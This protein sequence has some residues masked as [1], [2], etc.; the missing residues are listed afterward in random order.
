MFEGKRYMT[1]GV[2]E[3]VG[4][5]IQIIIWSMID[6][7]RKKKDFNI[8]YLQVFELKTIEINGLEFQKITHKQ[9]VEPYSVSKVFRVEK[10]ANCKIFVISNKDEEGQEYSVMMLSHEY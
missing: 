7:I 4:L 9:E 10:P 6:D 5:D 8:D 3:M 1:V 2:K